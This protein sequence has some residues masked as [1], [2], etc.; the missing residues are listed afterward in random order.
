MESEQSLSI[1]TLDSSYGRP[2]VKDCCVIFFRH[3]KVIDGPRGEYSS[4]K[5]PWLAGRTTTRLLISCGRRQKQRS[6]TR[7]LEG[8]VTIDSSP[9]RL[10]WV[11]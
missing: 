6:Q 5:L 3:G 8:K 10:L 2:K 11:V 9:P 4:R 1:D 7:M